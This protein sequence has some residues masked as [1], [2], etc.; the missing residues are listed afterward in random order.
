MSRTQDPLIKSFISV[1]ATWVKE[2]NEAYRVNSQQSINGS[3]RFISLPDYG[4][5]KMMSGINQI[6]TSHIQDSRVGLL[7]CQRTRSLDWSGDTFD[8]NAPHPTPTKDSRLW[9]EWL[10]L[11]SELSS[12][13][14]SP[15]ISDNTA[16]EEYLTGTFRT[17]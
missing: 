5:H 4:S 10:D 3:S 13:A 9:P 8:G 14:V 15:M 17:P 16:K 1:S 6:V 11:H 2:R 12:L 7:F